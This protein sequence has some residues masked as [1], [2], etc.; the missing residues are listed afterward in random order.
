MLDGN[1]IVSES[2]VDGGGSRLQG[3]KNES[4]SGRVEREMG[5][6]GTHDLH[7]SIVEDLIG[8]DVVLPISAS[9]LRDLGLVEA[10]VEASSEPLD[11]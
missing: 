4:E 10:L 11:G 6:E 1:E 9:T 3:K 8:E 2:F 7:C 5:G